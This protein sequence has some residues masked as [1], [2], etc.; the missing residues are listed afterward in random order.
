I[1]ARSAEMHFY[2]KEQ[3]VRIT[4]E[5]AEIQRLVQDVDVF[6]I[7]NNVL[8]FSI[9][10]DSKFNMEKKIQEDTNSEISA[11]LVQTRH[12]LAT[13]RKKEAIRDG[14]AFGSGLMERIKWGDVFQSFRDHSDWIRR[15]NE[16]DTEWHLRIS[17]AFGSLLFVLVGAPIGI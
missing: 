2:L 14:F 15:C 13:A 9:P 5:D 17:M 11:E 16:L 10:P 12:L 3:Q 4:L 8:P 7:N 1:Q 6:L